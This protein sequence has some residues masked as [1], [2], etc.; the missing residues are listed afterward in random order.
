MSPIE[1]KP[2]SPQLADESVT[3]KNLSLGDKEKIAN[4]VTFTANYL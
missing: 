4:V 1:E 3:I 2:A